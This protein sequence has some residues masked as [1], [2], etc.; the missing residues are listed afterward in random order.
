[1]AAWMDTMAGSNESQIFPDVETYEAIIQAWLRTASRE[2]L[3][4]AH[5]LAL[6]LLD[7]PTASPN[8]PIQ[9]RLL[10]YRPLILSW[11]MSKD[12]D[13]PSKVQ[14]IV[15]RLDAASQS[16][17]AL[18]PDGRILQSL[19]ASNLTHQLSAIETEKESKES[20][21]SA[22]GDV[23]ESA[24]KCTRALDRICDEFQ[25]TMELTEEADLFLET[26]PFEECILA[27]HNVAISASKV[28]GAN[29]SIFEDS[30]D[31]M[32]RVVAAFETC[33]RAVQQRQSPGSLGVREDRRRS[34]QFRHLLV[35]GHRVYSAFLMCLPQLAGCCT[36]RE[37]FA[38]KQ[39][40]LD[41]YIGLVESMVRR[42]AEYES[43]SVHDASL[44][45][46][47]QEIRPFYLQQGVLPHGYR[48]SSRSKLLYDDGFS[49]DTTPKR[50]KRLGWSRNAFYRHVLDYLSEVDIEKVN[51]G[52]YVRICTL[53]KDSSLD[54]GD[55]PS[56][57]SREL[58]GRLLDQISPLFRDVE[59]RRSWRGLVDRSFGARDASVEGPSAPRR[60]T[61]SL[62][63]RS[64]STRRPHRGSRR[65]TISA[66]K[67]GQY[68]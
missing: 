10:T 22:F 25:H 39:D 18:R 23:F 46:S 5:D 64:P 13:G 40:L 54:R 17:P 48:F 43:A 6:S 59:K 41:K 37:S 14:R 55:G 24:K 12:A 34:I 29:D 21:V 20:D 15:D 61:G 8:N 45:S 3:E 51:V 2:G 30:I 32:L 9:P 58:A 60:H 49:S 68:A 4:R 11:I 66:R 42:N 7:S 63:G 52:D 33:I 16:L 62:R 1:M 50:L 67:T 28:D 56:A 35:Y 53:V 31:E 26:T 57:V 38:G 19:T 44:E 65:P 27:W 47:E 36:H